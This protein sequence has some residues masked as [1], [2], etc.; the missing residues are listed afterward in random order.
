ML[1]RKRV[2]YTAQEWMFRIYTLPAGEG[3]NAYAKAKN[4]LD[5]YFSRL[6]NV[7]FESHQFRTTSQNESE[8]IE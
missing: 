4:A 8:T 5:K 6:S 7:A 3:D 1:T 2:C